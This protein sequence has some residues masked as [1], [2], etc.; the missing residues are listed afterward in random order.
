MARR[1]GQGH[2]HCR[3]AKGT[4]VISCAPARPLLVAALAS[5]CGPRRLTAEQIL[6]MIAAIAT[7][8]GTTRYV[9]RILETALDGLRPS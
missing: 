1:S 9:E 8:H 2:D 6:D 7:I 4:P 3:V 5:S